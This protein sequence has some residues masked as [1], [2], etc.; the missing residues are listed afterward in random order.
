[1]HSYAPL[2]YNDDDDIIDNFLDNLINEKVIPQCKFCPETIS[3][4]DSLRDRLTAT[5]KNKK[6]I[7]KKIKIDTK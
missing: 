7:Y 3:Y 1:M 6:K 2:K 4:D 5:I